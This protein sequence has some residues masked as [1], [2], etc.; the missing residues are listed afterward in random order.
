MPP[1][2]RTTIAPSATKAMGVAWTSTSTRLAGAIILGS[3]AA[4]TAMM[5]RSS[6]CGAKLR[7]LAQE[8]RLR[9][10]LSKGGSLRR[11]EHHRAH[12]GHLRYGPGT[13]AAAHA[14]ETSGCP[15]SRRLW[16]PVA[17][18]FVYVH[19]PARYLLRQQ[20]GLLRISA[21]YGPGETIRAGGYQGRQFREAREPDDGGDGSECLIL[22]QPNIGGY[23]VHDRR[24]DELLGRHVRHGRTPGEHRGPLRLRLCYLLYDLARVGG[25][26]YGTH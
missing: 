14:A 26:V 21:K 16:L 8:K 20:H 24:F 15:A 2:T 22:V 23:P 11:V 18:G 25:R 1:E 10:L 4:A 19:D 5:T 9:D 17:T 13:P 6:N 7:I 12:F 3:T